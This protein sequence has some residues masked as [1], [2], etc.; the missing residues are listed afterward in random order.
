MNENYLI[1]TACLQEGIIESMNGSKMIVEGVYYDLNAKQWYIIVQ[2]RDRM[3]IPLLNYRK[4]WTVKNIPDSL[5]VQDL[6][7]FELLESGKEIWFLRPGG[8]QKVTMHSKIVS[9]MEVHGGRYYFDQEEL[10]PWDR[11]YVTWFTDK[12]E[13]LAELRYLKKEQPRT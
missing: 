3:L 12:K 2:K 1:L 8:K 13:A 11:L 9:W 4:T 10:L 5:T 6:E 7:R